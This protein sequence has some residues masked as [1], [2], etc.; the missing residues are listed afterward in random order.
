M[1]VSS[2]RHQCSD[3]VS[4]STL[5][6]Q[7]HHDPSFALKFEHTSVVGST[8][9][10]RLTPKNSL[11][12]QFIR[13]LRVLTGD[14]HVKVG[15]SLESETSDIQVIHFHDPTSGRNVTIVDMPGFDDSHEG[16][17]DTDI[18]NRSL[19]SSLK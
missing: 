9:T 4:I 3:N 2:I 6:Y 10:L 8:G 5:L 7:Q 11:Y 19:N 15:N 13:L 18:L 16:V 12:L 17:S 14:K 1:S